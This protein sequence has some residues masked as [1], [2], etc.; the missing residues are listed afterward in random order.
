MFKTDFRKGCGFQAVSHNLGLRRGPLLG[1]FTQTGY[2]AWHQPPDSVKTIALL[3]S[4]L[5]FT[6][7]ALELSAVLRN[8]IASS[9]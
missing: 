6:M 2:W 3:S 8:E 1:D 9:D 7:L 4:R 5:P